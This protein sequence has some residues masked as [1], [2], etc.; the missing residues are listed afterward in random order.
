MSWNIYKDLLNNIRTSLAKDKHIDILGYGIDFEISGQKIKKH[1]IDLL[2]EHGNDYNRYKTAIFCKYLD[3]VIDEDILIKADSTIRDCN[4]TKGIIIS[5]L[6]FTEEALLQAKYLDI[7]LIKL[8]SQPYENNLSPNIRILI[9]NITGL[10]I[11]PDE[12]LTDKEDIK[13]L[14]VLKEVLIDI[15]RQNSHIIKTDGSKIHINELFDNF[16]NKISS[17]EVLM[18]K[19]MIF[20]FPKGY[21]ITSKKFPL[22]VFLSN[23]EVKGHL[24]Y[25]DSVDTETEEYICM[26]IKSVFGD[27]EYI[28]SEDGSIKERNRVK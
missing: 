27:K 28:L 8:T 21:Y 15:F 12:K 24:S 4:L 18:E 6:G 11:I 22:K 20:E 2:T 5:K 10:N 14:D 1:Q 17:R 13:K 26:I 19:Q 16:F 7:E 25:Q 23:I 3:R 9:P